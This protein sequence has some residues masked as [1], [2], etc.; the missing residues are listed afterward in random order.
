M[1]ADALTVPVLSD[2]LNYSTFFGYV[3]A[4]E[5]KPAITGDLSMR[6]VIIGANARVGIFLFTFGKILSVALI[7][8]RIDELVPAS[9]RDILAD[10]GAF[11]T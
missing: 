4:G 7:T 5:A 8:S 3:F 9:K 11:V 1:P 10:Y 6:S 2:E